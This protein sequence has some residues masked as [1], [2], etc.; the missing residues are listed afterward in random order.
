M[1][2]CLFL[3]THG[4]ALILH[5][6]TYCIFSQFKPSDSLTKIYKCLFSFEHKMLVEGGVFSMP[7]SSCMDKFTIGS[8]TSLPSQ[9]K[10]SISFHQLTN[11]NGLFDVWWMAHQSDNQL[12]FYLYP[13]ISFPYNF[14]FVNA[15]TLRICTGA[16]IHPISCSDHAPITLT[17]DHT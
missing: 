14:F 15:P 1:F 6:V 16:S 8:K 4:K 7:Y 12:T 3:Q 17:P 5:V 9:E 10:Q 2:W 11:K 13:Q